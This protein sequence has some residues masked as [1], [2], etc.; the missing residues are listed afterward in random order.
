MDDDD[1]GGN[2]SGSC[3]TATT[4][5]TVFLQN[6]NFWNERIC[7][8]AH[9]RSTLVSTITFTTINLQHSS[10]PFL[11]LQTWTLLLPNSLKELFSDYYGWIRSRMDNGNKVDLLQWKEIREN[12]LNLHCKHMAR[13]GMTFYLNSL[14]DTS[15]SQIEVHH[16]HIMM[17]VEE[18]QNVL[19]TFPFPLRFSL[20]TLYHILHIF[21]PFFHHHSSF[22]FT[23]IKSTKSSMLCTNITSAPAIQPSQ[24]DSEFGSWASVSFILI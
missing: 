15:P 13:D 7:L 5:S 18:T 19:F 23:S 24:S 1:D 9:V 14:T 12:I 6:W 16:G 4:S 21:L 17:Q 8:L 20:H 3:T 2:S 22:S 11:K 10:D